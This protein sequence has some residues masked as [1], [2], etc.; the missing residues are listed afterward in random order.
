MQLLRDFISTTEA[1]EKQ[2]LGYLNNMKWNIQNSI[3]KFFDDGA[4]PEREEVKSSPKL[5]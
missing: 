4:M 2:A 1:S 5:E 3:N